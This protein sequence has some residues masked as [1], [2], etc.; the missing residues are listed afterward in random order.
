MLKLFLQSLMYDVSRLPVPSKISNLFTKVIEI[1]TH[2]L[3]APPQT[4]FIL[5]FRV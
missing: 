4:T 3:G 2:K 1:H 5:T